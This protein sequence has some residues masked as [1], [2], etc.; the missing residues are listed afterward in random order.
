MPRPNSR[1]SSTRRST[2][3]NSISLLQVDLQRAIRRASILP[4]RCKISFPRTH[5]ELVFWVAGDEAH[6]AP[7][8][9]R[10]GDSPRLDP[11]HPMRNDN[12]ENALSVDN[13][14]R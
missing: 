1:R 3:S 5:S 10:S 8:H 2:K 11:S 13:D 4:M 6:R 7:S 9:R 14:F 12:S